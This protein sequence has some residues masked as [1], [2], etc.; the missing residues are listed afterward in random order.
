MASCALTGGAGFGRKRF[1]GINVTRPVFSAFMILSR[2]E[3]VSSVS[4]TTC[5]K[6]C[7]KGAGQ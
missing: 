6:L 2:R 1:K 4:T 3:A 5:H 7:A